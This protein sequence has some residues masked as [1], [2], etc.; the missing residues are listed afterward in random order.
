MGEAAT[1]GTT[2]GSVDVS[3]PAGSVML[4]GKSIGIKSGE[5][6]SVASAL[7][8]SV[9]VS[10]DVRLQSGAGDVSISSGSSAE[11]SVSVEGGSV[12]VQGAGS[13]SVGSGSGS[14]LEMSSGAS[15][16]GESLSLKGKDGVDVIGSQFSLAAASGDV[17]VTASEG[18]I[19]LDTKSSVVTAS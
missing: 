13:V 10:N 12:S 11:H 14:T 3:A 6:A 8:G 5:I 4:D 19:L 9:D 17:S 16:S 18:S 2:G 15:L 1:A 7:G